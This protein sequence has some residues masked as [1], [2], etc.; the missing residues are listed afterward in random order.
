MAAEQLAG[1]GARVALFDQAPSVG[2]KF[3]LAGRGGLNLTHSEDV[4][5]MVDRYGSSSVAVA[6]ALERFGPAA[7]RQWCAELGEPT[8]IGSSGRVFPESFR[9]TRLL[10]AWLARL[11]ELGVEIEVR[12]RWA[13][14]AEEEPSTPELQRLIFADREGVERLVEADAVVLALGGASWPQLGSDGRWV[15]TLGAVGVSV[16]HLEAANCGFSARWSAEFARRFAGVPLKNVR[17][18]VG[19]AVSRGEVMITETGVEGGG[20]YAVGSAL[21]ALTAAGSGAVL[22]VDLQPDR[23]VAQVRERLAGRRPK[24]SQ[25]SMLRRTLALAPVAIGLMRE[26]TGNDLPADLDALAGLVKAVPLALDGPEPIARA[27]SSAGGVRWTELDE[28]LMLHR[29]PGTFVVGEM[30]DWE[31]PTGGYLLQA[32]FSQAVVAAEGAMAWLGSGPR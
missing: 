13:G 29:R 32:T 28:A 19:P 31:A 10:R 25:S 23:S 20:V 15:D 18:S 9:A 22:E 2:R 6:P 21:R 16:A 14:W 8:F 1:R 12:Q 3:L 24:E 30:I 11:D 5:A 17:L 27:I 4:S 26:A 7:L